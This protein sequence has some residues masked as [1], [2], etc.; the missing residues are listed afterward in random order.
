MSAAIKQLKRR[1]PE[2]DKVATKNKRHFFLP[3]INKVFL[4]PILQNLK[5]R[6]ILYKFFFE[7]NPLDEQKKMPASKKGFLFRS[8]LL[9]EFLDIGAEPAQSHVPPK[10]GAKNGHI[11]QMVLEGQYGYQTVRLVLLINLIYLCMGLR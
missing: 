2:S 8:E 10:Y 9:A 6:S 5:G 11:S 7:N 1:K 4:S 3:K